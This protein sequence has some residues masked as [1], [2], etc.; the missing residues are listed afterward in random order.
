MNIFLTD[1]DLRQN[2]RNMV[3]KHIV[4]MPVESAQMLCTALHSCGMNAPY[5][6]THVNHPDNIWCRQSLD[7]WLYLKWLSLMICREYTFRYGKI[8]KSEDIIRSLPTP[9]LPKTGRTELPNCMDEHYIVGDDVV[10][11]YR[12]YYK[13]GKSHI[14]SWK[15]REKPIWI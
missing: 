9:N 11:N 1:L 13:F 15:N 2:A 7:N 5:K 6:A 14:H 10:T 8:H 4:K 3:D 12:N